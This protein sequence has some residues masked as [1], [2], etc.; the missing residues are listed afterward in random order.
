MDLGGRILPGSV[1]QRWGKYAKALLCLVSAALIALGVSRR[2]ELSYL[3]YGMLAIGALYPLFGLI[4]KNG[5]ILGWIGANSY[6]LYLVEG[7]LMGVVGRFKTLNDHI[8][9]YLLAYGFCIVLI[10][11][12]WNRIW[13]KAINLVQKY[14]L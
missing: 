11:V 9:L 8:V 4:R 2:I 3:H 1:A 13:K 6:F 7:K 12:V 5:K 10:T 14:G